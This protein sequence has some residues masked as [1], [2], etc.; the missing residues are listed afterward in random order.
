M[1]LAMPRSMATW[2]GFG[3]CSAMLLAVT[4]LTSSLTARAEDT[5]PSSPQAPGA[6]ATRDDGDAALPVA[7]R[8]AMGTPAFVPL[9]D[10]S[11]AGLAIPDVPD[12]FATRRWTL[13]THVGFGT[14]VGEFGLESEYSPH[15]IVG[16]GIGVGLGAVPKG[17]NAFRGALLARLR[18]FRGKKNALVL[19][20]AYA[21]GGFARFGGIS[22]GEGESDTPPL[23][24]RTTRAHWAQFDVGWERRAPSGFLLRM[25]VGGA[26]LLN[27]GDLE[28][29]PE[30]A[31]RCVSVSS[32]TLFTLD[33]AVGYAGPV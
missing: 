3:P 28:C 29:I 17:Y 25:S 22:F 5:H 20:A 12:S 27:P 8:P 13:E 24:D 10:A 33:V 30:E 31:A 2:I 7:A 26:V 23:A 16:L 21:F 11:D 19:G 9:R 32:Q 4:S 14:P 18:P 6:P 1:G 15:P